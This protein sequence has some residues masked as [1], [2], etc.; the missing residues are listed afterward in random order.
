[1]GCVSFNTDQSWTTTPR[2]ADVSL[3][4]GTTYTIRVT[5]RSYNSSI[6]GAYASISVD[7]IIVNSAP[8]G[9]A[10]ATI[11]ASPSPSLSWTA[12]TAGSSARTL[13][14]TI[15]YKVYRDTA[16]TVTTADFL[17]TAATNASTDYNALGNTTYYYSILDVDTNS[18]ESPLALE[19][20]IL[21]QPST[22][23]TP[24]FANV[25]TTSLTVNWSAPGGGGSPR[26]K[27]QRA[28]DVGGVPG[29]WAQ[30]GTT[31]TTS[32]ADSG[33][34]GGTSYWY[35]II[36][37]NASGNGSYSTAAKVTTT[38]AAK[39]RPSLFIRGWLKIR[40]WLR[41]R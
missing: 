13:N 7:N 16:A 31:A 26:Y 11:D 17:G 36:G 1:M 8:T 15:P 24:T 37:Y 25:N 18:N 28:P 9:F 10:I 38:V 23:D 27:I 4:G 34:S 29:S 14:T 6:A 35:R 30:T 41:M 2:S 40:G 5:I 12:S 3:T 33:L 32:T 20:S 21:T 39:T 19:K 22:P